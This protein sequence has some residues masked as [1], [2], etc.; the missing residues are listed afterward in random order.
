MRRVKIVCPKAI[1]EIDLLLDT[2]ARFTTLNWEILKDIGYEPATISN[3]IR[4]VTANGIIET[5]FFKIKKISI[6]ELSCKNVE[7]ICHTVPEL[8]EIDGLLGLSFLSHFKTIIDYKEKV[9]E[10]I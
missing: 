3:R 6:G 1:R 7:I 5:P 2:G 10:I 9:L 4:I 8:V